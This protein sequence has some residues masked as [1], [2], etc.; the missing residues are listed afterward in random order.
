MPTYSTTINRLDTEQM[1]VAKGKDMLKMAR[2]SKMARMTVAGGA[3]LSA[4]AIGNVAADGNRSGLLDCD[5]ACKV[6]IITGK[7]DGYADYQMLGYIL[8]DPSAHVSSYVATG[9]GEIGFTR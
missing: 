7:T 6:E 1:L 8:V 3:L 2:I 4:L 9:P 5:H